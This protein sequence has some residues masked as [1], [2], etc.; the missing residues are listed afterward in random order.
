MLREVAGDRGRQRRDDQP[1]CIIRARKVI[2]VKVSHKR[3]FLRHRTDLLQKVSGTGR[4]AVTIARSK[5]IAKA[6]LPARWRA[7]RRTAIHSGS[8]A[9]EWPSPTG[10]GRTDPAHRR[11]APGHGDRRIGTTA[12]G[13]RPGPPG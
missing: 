7:P 11:W 4:H 1:R 6:A 5:R 8:T 13:R 3:S 2:A 10:Q 12:S 9:P